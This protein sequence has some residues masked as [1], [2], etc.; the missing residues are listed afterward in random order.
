MGI[1]QC[2]YPN[3]NRQDYE[4]YRFSRDLNEEPVNVTS[5]PRGNHWSNHDIKS[6]AISPDESQLA[7][8]STRP[9]RNGTYSIWLMNLN[10]DGSASDFDC[11][12]NTAL[13]DINGDNRCE[14]IY[15][16]LEGAV[17]YRNLKFTEATDFLISHNSST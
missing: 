12:R 4:I 11:T 17:E 3:A 9:N 13:P 15:Y 7:F 10:G 1:A 5:V 6:F 16:D 8:T 2:E 14:Y